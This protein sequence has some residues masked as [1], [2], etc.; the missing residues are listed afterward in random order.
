MARRLRTKYGQALCLIVLTGYGQEEDRRCAHEAGVDQY[1][2]K[3]VDL[4]A[5]ARLLASAGADLNESKVPDGPAYG[6]IV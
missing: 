5:L 4:E 1:L 6:L 3:P 2:A